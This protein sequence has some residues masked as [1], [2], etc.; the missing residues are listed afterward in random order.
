MRR[1]LYVSRLAGLLLV[2]MACAWLSRSGV[3]DPRH[4]PT[5]SRPNLGLVDYGGNKQN[6][7]IADAPEC[8]F[9]E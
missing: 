7:L 4:E 2:G 1:R 9:L 8:V 6:N 3:S 5:R